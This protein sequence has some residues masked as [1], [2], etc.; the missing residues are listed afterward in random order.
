[1]AFTIG[2]AA[3][4]ASPAMAEDEAVKVNVAYDGFTMTTAPMQYALAKGLFKKHGLDVNLVYVEGGSVL[5]Q[6]LVGGSIDIAQNGY[7]P[8]IAAAVAGADVVIIGSMANKLPFQ[9]VVDASIQN[10]EQLRGKSIA[11]SKFGSSTDTAAK[12]ALKSLGLTQN[13]VNI[14]QLGGEGTRA[15]AFETKQV[16]GLMVQYPRTQEMVDEGSKLLV[17]VTDIVKDYPNTAYVTSKTYLA[18]HPDVVKRFLMAVGEGLRGFK[19]NPQDAME[20]TSSFLKMKEGPAVEQA[21]RFY[22]ERVYPADLRPSIPGIATVLTELSNTLPA[23]ASIKPESL[24]DTGALD[25]LEK[26]GFFETLN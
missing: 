24:V 18:E 3:A 2:L 26:D 5:T 7:T 12:F 22:S 25:A 17:D 4:T 6:A 20:V 21:F 16:Q 10:A 1:M 14:L 13:D 23:A 19:A 8:S 15:A 11:I 9:L